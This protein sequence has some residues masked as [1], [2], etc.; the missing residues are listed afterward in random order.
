[1]LI[2]SLMRSLIISK[3]GCAIPT[4]LSGICC[5]V[6]LSGA[7]PA[8]ALLAA[9]KFLNG[10]S[11]SLLAYHIPSIIAAAYWH[12]KSDYLEY[13]VPVVCAVLFLAHP[14]G[15]QAWGY[16][17]FWL[18]PIFASLFMPSVAGRALTASFL[19]HAVGSVL[20]LYTLQTTWTPDY[21]W[22]LMLVV[23]FERCAI[24]AGILLVEYAQ[25]MVT[26]WV[27]TYAGQFFRHTVRN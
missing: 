6:P 25:R 7:L 22:S 14:V 10:M 16:T 5:A 21:W 18:V 15:A 8:F 26:T 13:I 3:I 27:A 4:I 20:W 11:H 2:I 19:A 9:G 23:P 1:M 12:R 24:A 17:L